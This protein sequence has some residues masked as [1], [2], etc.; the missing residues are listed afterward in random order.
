MKGDLMGQVKVSII[1][2]CLNSN[3][4][5]NKTIASVLSQSYRNL[6]Y[7]IID[8]GSK[9]GTTETIKS[10]NVDFQK[11]GVP[12][13]WISEPDRGIYDAMNKGIAMATG[14]IIGIINSDDWYESD[15]VENVIMNYEESIDIYHG[16]LRTIK[17]EKEKQ[18][19]VTNSN[20]LKN[21]VMIEHPTCF[22]KKASYEKIGRFNL[23]YK[24]ASDLDFMLRALKANLK[25][26]KIDAVLANFRMGGES[27]T[28]LNVIIETLKIKL[29]YGIIDKKQYIRSRISVGLLKA[30]EMILR[31]S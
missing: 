9:D 3:R 6:E 19:F 25:F 18:V 24:I 27:S 17:N 1:T 28:N 23:D 7:L 31:G 16:F 21:G 22:V 11:S 30:K 5:I 2:V 14:E 15:A 8:G 26:K 20:E 4:T 29:K 10:Y 12:Y 13:R